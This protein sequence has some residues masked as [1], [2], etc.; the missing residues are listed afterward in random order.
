MNELLLDRQELFEGKGNQTKHLSSMI[1]PACFS[2]NLMQYVERLDPK[3]VRRNG[4]WILE[5]YPEKSM[6]QQL[7]EGVLE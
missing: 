3:I 2:H 5:W 6:G 1:K 4:P 7:G